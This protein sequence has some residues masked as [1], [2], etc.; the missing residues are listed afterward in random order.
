MNRLFHT[1]DSVYGLVLR[2]A[3]GGLMLPHGLQKLGYLGGY[4]FEGT[5]GFFDG[6]GIPYAVGVLIILAES[7][8]AAMLIAGALTRWWAFVLSATMV[9]AMVTLHGAN[10]FFLSAGGVEYNLALLAMTGLLTVF[11]AGKWSVDG[12]IAARSSE[13]APVEQTLRRAA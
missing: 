12:W 11:G 3:A 6:L 4:G 2:L 7:V 1:D 9:G 13:A 5:M 8:G 10:G